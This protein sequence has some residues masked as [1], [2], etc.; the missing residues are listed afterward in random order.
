MGICYQLN[1]DFIRVNLLELLHLMIC[2]FWMYAKYVDDGLIWA[3]CLYTQSDIV[4]RGDSNTFH[5][6]NDMIEN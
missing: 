6:R 1:C 3:K 2:A 5:N 4:G